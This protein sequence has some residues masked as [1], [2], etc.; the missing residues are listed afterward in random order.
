M[1]VGIL[2]GD[3]Y[4]PVRN[5]LSLE[6]QQ[7]ENVSKNS[8]DKSLI[9]NYT[10]PRKNEIVERAISK[11]N[12]NLNKIDVTKK[13]NLNKEISTIEPKQAE[14][15]AVEFVS[16]K[17]FKAGVASSCANSKFYN[18][19]I[20]LKNPL[21]IEN[22]T[23]V[24]VVKPISCKY[25]NQ[26]QTTKKCGAF[27]RVQIPFSEAKKLYPSSYNPSKRINTLGRCGL[28]QVEIIQD[29]QV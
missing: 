12:A 21:N 15:I 18:K 26:A 3:I 14:I 2:L 20:E 7:Q 9:A 4:Q 24:D 19:Q 27:P 29:N 17:I 25:S 10:S 13:I 28:A 22:N 1:L 8:S 6:K 23:V 5:T 11:P 16:D